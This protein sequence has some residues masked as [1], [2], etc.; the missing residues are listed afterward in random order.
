MGQLENKELADLFTGLV[1][2]RFDAKD[3]QMQQFLKTVENVLLRRVHSLPKEDLVKIAFS[4]SQLARQ[5]KVGTGSTSV[6]KTLEYMIR[7][8]W[9][10]I[11]DLDS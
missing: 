7:N 4:Y 2:T 8:K 5:R 3:N 11:K 10:Q 9:A 1:L 6:I